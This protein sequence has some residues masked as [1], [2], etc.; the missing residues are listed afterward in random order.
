MKNNWHKVSM[1]AVFLLYLSVDV[2][3]FVE[4]WNLYYVKKIIR[5]KRKINGHVPNDIF[6]SYEKEHGYV[7]F[8]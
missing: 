1:N 8:F 3:T 7:E 6:K 4:A 5:Y 2:E